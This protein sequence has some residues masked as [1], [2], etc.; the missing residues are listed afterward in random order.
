MILGRPRDRGVVLRRPK[1]HVEATRVAGATSRVSTADGL[2][3]E[4][5]GRTLSPSVGR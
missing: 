1:V 3:A 5:L 2:V 4:M